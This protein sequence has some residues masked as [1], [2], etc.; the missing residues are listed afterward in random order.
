MFDFGSLRKRYSF[1]RYF[2]QYLRIHDETVWD[3]F[4]V[5]ILGFGEVIEIA[6]LRELIDSSWVAKMPNDVS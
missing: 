5:R 3:G 4:A 6:K 2:K 1:R